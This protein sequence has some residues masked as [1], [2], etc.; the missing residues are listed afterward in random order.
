[1]QGPSLK[2]VS[3]FID[4]QKNLGVSLLLIFIGFYVTVTPSIPEQYGGQWMGAA[5]T[6]AGIY[7]GHRIEGAKA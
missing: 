3:E 2:E 1:V 6:A 7:I 5:M 4:A